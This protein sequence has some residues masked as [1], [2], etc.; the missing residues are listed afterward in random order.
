MQKVISI[1]QVENKMNTIEKE[2]IELKKSIN[3]IK[4]QEI[5]N[6]LPELSNSHKMLKKLW[7]NE[8]DKIWESYL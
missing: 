7:K 8:D 5:T 2:L 6:K 3:Q 1:N 4:N